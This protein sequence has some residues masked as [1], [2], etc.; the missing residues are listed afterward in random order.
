MAY[1]NAGQDA[2]GISPQQRSKYKHQQTPSDQLHSHQQS[3]Q[4][5]ALQQQLNIQQQQQVMASQQQSIAKSSDNQGS[6][7]HS[8]Y[9]NS[10]HIQLHSLQQYIGSDSSHCLRTQH[11]YPHAYANV[12]T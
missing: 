2:P 6:V 1:G 7:Y 3:H 11:Y 4:N 12:G 8:F 5:L 10:N 9:N